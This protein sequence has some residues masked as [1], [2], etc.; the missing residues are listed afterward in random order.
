L[1]CGSEPLRQ[2]LD[3]AIEEYIL[4]TDVTQKNTQCKFVR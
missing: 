2:A 1:D 3:L 4:V